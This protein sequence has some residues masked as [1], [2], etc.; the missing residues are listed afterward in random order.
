M[1]KEV[2]CSFQESVYSTR[3]GMDLAFFISPQENV[4]STRCG[5][6][7]A[8]YIDKIGTG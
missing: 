2:V 7:F 4:I 3:C 8:F 1:V 6:G 5:R